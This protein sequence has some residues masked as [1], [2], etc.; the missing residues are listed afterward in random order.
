MAGF[1]GELCREV[2]PEEPG[3]CDAAQAYQNR[4]GQLDCATVQI[5]L[6]IGSPKR[7]SKPVCHIVGGRRRSPA[8]HHGLG[9]DDANSPD[10]Q[11]A[12][13]A[14]AAVMAKLKAAIKD[15]QGIARLHGERRVEQNLVGWYP[16]LSAC[17]HA[18]IIGAPAHR[19]KVVT[20]V[21]D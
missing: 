7:K 16:R 6:K 20:W 5:F 15:R 9:P 12:W 10:T 2:K 4:P 14:A 8:R 21:K 11:Y 3:I 1:V 18:A 13:P 19:M 17:F